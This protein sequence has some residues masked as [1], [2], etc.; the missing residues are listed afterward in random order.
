MELCEESARETE[1]FAAVTAATGA[2]GP[3]LVK[4]TALLGAEYKLQ[5]GTRRDIVSI[6]SE[7][8]PV[9]DLL[10]KL[11]GREDLD[12]ACTDWMAEARE[13]SYDM[14]DDIDGF[15]LGLERD[16]GG[17]IQWEATD[18]PFKE[19]ME[20]VKDVSKRCGKM[21]KVGDT[22]CNSTKLTTDPRALFL[23]KDAS[24]L[25]G[26]ERKKEKLIEQLQEHEMVCTVG[27]AGMGK[28]TLADLVYQ[29]IGDGFQCRAFVSVH[30]SPNMTE[31]LGTI[32][33]QVSSWCN[34]CWQWHQ[35]CSPTK[36]R[37][38]QIN[39]PL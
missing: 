23:H 17:F 24:E 9:H 8:E 11:G 34:V 14:E 20:R 12:V 28:T 18:S 36:Y 38:R 4:L 39:F 31:I 6:K 26:M 32:L 16:D 1:W 25:V 35:T 37:K 22:I 3:V 5:E 13:L 21:Q 15:T 10:G 33:S 27:S 29:T 30:P 2:L 7:L 19:F